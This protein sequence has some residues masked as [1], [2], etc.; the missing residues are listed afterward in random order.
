MGIFD[1]LFKRTGPSRGSGPDAQPPRAENLAFVQAIDAVARLDSAEN[2]QTLYEAMSKA[3]FL[4]PTNQIPAAGTL[5]KQVV[6]SDTRVSIPIIRDAKGKNVVPAFTDEEALA[7]WSGP[8]AW[9]ALQGSAFFQGVVTTEA[10]EIAINPFRPGKPMIRP[11]GRI[12]RA[13]FQALAEGRIPRADNREG[14]IE[15]TVAKPQRVLLGMPA[16]MPR[17]DI[18][19]ALAEAAK[20]QPAIRGLYFCQV[21]FEN[22][23]PHGAIAI[24]FL[25]GTSTQDCNV[26]IR[27][28]GSAIQPLLTKDYFYDFFPS[29]MG[30]A[31]AIMKE[32]KRFY[33]PLVG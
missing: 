32:G 28:L 9:F 27:A 30:I 20:T 26:S 18:F 25:A 24:D 11:F 16:Q 6:Q 1:K 5:G 22:G 10:D 29:G 4:V 19:D 2:R 33:V 31:D 23:L 14:M 7:H 21:V 17:K 12:T 3:W 8:S 15:V 13:E